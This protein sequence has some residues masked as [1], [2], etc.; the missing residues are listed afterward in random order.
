MNETNH[1]G[2]V[3][4]EEGSIMLS[5]AVFG[6]MT[7]PI[8]IGAIAVIAVIAILASGYVKAPPDQAY[9]IS[10]MKKECKVLIGRAGR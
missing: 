6:S 7:L 9:I 5:A 1:K 4:N 8:M 10:G 2:I 3:M